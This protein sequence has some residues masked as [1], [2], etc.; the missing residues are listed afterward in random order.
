MVSCSSSIVI[1]SQHVMI[2]A[3]RDPNAMQN[4]MRNQDLA[5]SQIENMPG[6]FNALRSMYENIQVSVN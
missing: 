6:G 4:M 1:C 2:A 5:M 3:G